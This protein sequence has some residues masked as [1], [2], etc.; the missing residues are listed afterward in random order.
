MSWWRFLKWWYWRKSLFW[1]QVQTKSFFKF[2]CN[3]TRLHFFYKR[4][5]SPASHTS[6]WIRGLFYDSYTPV[7]STTVQRYSPAFSKLFKRTFPSSNK[8]VFVI[9]VSLPNFS[10]KFV[11]KSTS[12]NW[13]DIYDKVW[14]DAPHRSWKDYYFMKFVLILKCMVVN[15]EIIVHYIYSIKCYHRWRSQADVTGIFF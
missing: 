6:G 2:D 11:E 15:V 12:E 9:K 3:Y 4:N 10:A 14:F 8:N 13:E 7:S 1:T 5:G